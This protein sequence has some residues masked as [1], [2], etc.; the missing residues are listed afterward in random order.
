MFDVANKIYGHIKPEYIKPELSTKLYRTTYAYLARFHSEK[1]FEEACQELQMPVAYLRDEEN[2]VSVKFGAQFAKLIRE[3]TGDPEIYRKIG[4]FFLSPDNISPIEYSLIANLTPYLVLKIANKFSRK[5]N[6]VS[7]FEVKAIGFNK[8]VF[9]VTSD[10]EM[11][12]DMAYNFLGI[13]EAFK[14]LYDLDWMDADLKIDDPTKIK[15]FAI[16]MRFS[17]LKHY[18]KRLARYTL[19]PT[20]GVAIG[21]GLWQTESHFGFPLLPVLTALCYILGFITYHHSRNLKI[22]KLNHEASLLRAREKNTS[23]FEKS[24]MLER[25]YQEAG[26]LKKLSSE[27]VGCTDPNIVIETCLKSI[28]SKFNYRRAAVFL[29]SKERAKLYLANSIGFENL[30]VDTSKIEFFYPNPDKKE[31][32]IATALEKGDTN[33]IL[34][35][36]SYKSILKAQ[37]K[38]LL[39]ALRV[40]SLII[41]PIQSKDKKFGAFILIR[42]KDEQLLD[43]QDKFLVENITN[44]LSLYFES[45][46]N[47]ESEIKLRSIFQKYVPRTVLEQITDNLHT[48]DGSLKPQKKEICS[49][50]MDLR[51]FTSACD[52]APPEHAFLLINSFADFATKCLAVE[53]AIIDNIIGDEIVCFFPS[54]PSDPGEHVTRALRSI[55]RLKSEF[56]AFTQKLKQQGFGEIKLGVGLHSGEAT[57]GSVGSDAKMNFTALGSTVN[58]ASRLQAL[59]KKFSTEAVTV[60]ASKRALEIVSKN[61]VD[62]RKFDSEILR[63]QAAATEFTVL[64][65]S[66]IQTLLV[67]C[68]DSIRRAA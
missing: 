29:L 21:F 36:D 64:N 16:T 40:G 4:H 25:R 45:A 20:L 23:L 52:G 3:K 1:I 15:S 24:Q 55:A 57:I 2:W 18:T 53:G 7:N 17:A 65:E 60:V 63:G 41:S 54:N 61:F 39:E 68:D 13:V 28:A 56:P 22:F 51:G 67:P 11:Y 58:T 5:S 66:D 59:S 9:S 14:E 6:V 62:S 37:N 19:I 34:D 43:N 50:F 44:Q 10:Q 12:I 35:I 33:L 38:F 47:F 48:S 46:S 26:L 31:G 32:F 30:P 49:V 27:L 42:E 8:Y